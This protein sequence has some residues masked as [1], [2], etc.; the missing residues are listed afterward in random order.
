MK[1]KTSFKINKTP[2]ITFP[3]K[4]S[5]KILKI[6]VNLYKLGYPT[7]PLW[8]TFESFQIAT[9]IPTIMM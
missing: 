7:V 3:P 5:P 2:H 4:L 1:T 9:Q 8:F 6:F